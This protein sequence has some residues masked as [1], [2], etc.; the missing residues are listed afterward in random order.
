MVHIYHFGTM[1]NTPGIGNFSAKTP[2]IEN[3]SVVSFIFKS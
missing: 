1:T 2:T 3:F